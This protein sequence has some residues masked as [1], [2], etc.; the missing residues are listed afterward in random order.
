MK[1]VSK[2]LN[3]YIIFI[4]C[5]SVCSI[6]SQFLKSSININKSLNGHS[7]ENLPVVTLNGV[8]ENGIA[9]GRVI[10]EYDLNCET[11][12]Q[13]TGAQ[14]TF[15]NTRIWMDLSNGETIDYLGRFN[16][17]VWNSN[18]SVYKAFEIVGETIENP[19]EVEFDRR[20]NAEISTKISYIADNNVAKLTVA[21]EW[22]KL[23]PTLYRDMQTLYF[24]IDDYHWW[25]LDYRYT[26]MVKQTIR[27]IDKNASPSDKKAI[28]EYS[29]QYETSIE[30]VAFMSDGFYEATNNN[31][32]QKLLGI[33]TEVPIAQRNEINKI[34]KDNKA[35]ELLSIR[36][37]FSVH[38]SLPFDDMKISDGGSYTT[39]NGQKYFYY[40]GGCAIKENWFRLFDSHLYS[41]N[42]RS[43]SKALK[44]LSSKPTQITNDVYNSYSIIDKSSNGKRQNNGYF[45]IES[46]H[47][48]CV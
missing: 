29:N 22:N 3:L 42:F 48:V 17:H 13:N 38:I 27:L 16:V 24:I 33:S 35:K 28:T 18:G 39:Q 2:L 1:I 21:V 25:H 30:C 43:N 10:V 46:T 47:Y 15:D 23:P 6:K 8:D 19:K 5:L 4:C 9:T 36:Y 20:G 31:E 11:N 14:Y 41:Y 32:K 37:E 45:M 34:L 44:D 7:S 12:D 26:P 40:V